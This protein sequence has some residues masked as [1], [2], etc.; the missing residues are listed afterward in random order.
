[1][2]EQFRF[3]IEAISKSNNERPA[4]LSRTHCLL[5]S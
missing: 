1:M 2:Q 3:S 5:R 4:K